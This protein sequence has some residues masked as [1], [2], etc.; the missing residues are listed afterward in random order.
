MAFAQK[1]ELEELRIKIRILENR[2]VEDQ[3]RIKQL[4]S[5]VTEADT[6]RAARVKLQG[7]LFIGDTDL[8]P[9]DESYKAKF[10]ELQSSLVAAQRLSR[11]LQ[12]EN[13]HLETKASEA[14][15]QLEMATLDREV[16]EEKAEASEGEVARM[17][18]KIAELELELAVL[19]EENGELR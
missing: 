1:R 7:K 3:E 13:A 19:R 6:L 9:T 17:T 18:E 8:N 12:S 14:V 10:Q 11:D 4:E 2:K 15:D 16:A 5:R